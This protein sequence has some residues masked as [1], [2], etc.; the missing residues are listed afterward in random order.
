MTLGQDCMDGDSHAESS[1]FSIHL[2]SVVSFKINPD[3]DFKNYRKKFCPALPCPALRTLLLCS[4][5]SLI[6][7]QN[8]HQV[9]PFR[10]RVLCKGSIIRL[11]Y[12][13]TEISNSLNRTLV[14]SLN[15]SKSDQHAVL[16][17]LSKA[18][19][20]SLLYVRCLAQ[21]P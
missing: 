20:I 18:S 3:A 4:F 5:F 7:L 1:H 2:A 10:F 8:P 19:K 12:N 15:I 14:H 16:N 11:D 13:G 9:L 17:T 6:P 21:I